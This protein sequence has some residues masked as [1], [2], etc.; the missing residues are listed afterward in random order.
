MGR[1]NIEIDDDLIER[2]MRTYRL[3]SKRE[4]VDLALRRLVGEPL[5]VDE[6][7][8]MEGTGWGG[9]LDELRRAE[10]ADEL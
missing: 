3:R 6:A 7:R 4:A 5:T 1:T 2:A 8:A 10:A 9:S